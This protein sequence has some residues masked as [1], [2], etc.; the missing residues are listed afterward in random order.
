MTTRMLL[1]RTKGESRNYVSNLGMS[2]LV[3]SKFN[4]SI[5]KFI[6]CGRK[7]WFYHI[8]NT[9][10]EILEPCVEDCKVHNILLLF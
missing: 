4:E 9:V 2:R 6:R 7:S 10:V 1:T 5:L 8:N 3:K